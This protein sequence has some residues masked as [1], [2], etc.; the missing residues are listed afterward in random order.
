MLR[1]PKNQ[2]TS[3]KEIKILNEKYN[4]GYYLIQHGKESIVVNEWA[5]EIIKEL[6]K[7]LDEK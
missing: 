5:G 4:G 6:L 3:M 7:R 1:L 2:G